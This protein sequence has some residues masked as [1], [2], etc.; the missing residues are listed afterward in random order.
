[1]FGIEPAVRARPDGESAIRYT[2]QRLL[3]TRWKINVIPLGNLTTYLY[4]QHGLVTG[5]QS[6]R[7]RMYSFLCSYMYAGLCM[8]LC[9]CVYVCI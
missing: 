1:M 4:K 7:F 6:V 9:M 3:E 2:S 8:Y 5:G